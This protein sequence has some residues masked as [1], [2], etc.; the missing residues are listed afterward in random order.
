MLAIAR[1]SSKE[2]RLFLGVEGGGEDVDALR[3]WRRRQEHEHGRRGGACHSVA[4]SSV[5]RPT[6]DAS[7]AGLPSLRIRKSSLRTRDNHLQQSSQSNQTQLYLHCSPVAPCLGS[8]PRYL[9]IDGGR[10]ASGHIAQQAFLPYCAVCSHHHSASC[11]TIPGTPACRDFDMAGLLL[12]RGDCNK[13]IA[14]QDPQ[15][16]T[17]D[18]TAAVCQ[19]PI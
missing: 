8:S 4:E 2:T 9:R 18:T 19:A 17:R 11:R 16:N 5:R 15:K 1:Q 14:T 10:S 13:D 6:A 12:S 3:C 7:F